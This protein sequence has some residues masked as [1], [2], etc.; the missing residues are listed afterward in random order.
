MY[1]IH[2]LFSFIIK[3][4]LKGGE[5]LNVYE[6]LRRRKVSFLGAKGELFGWD[7][8]QKVSFLGEIFQRWAFWVRILASVL[9]YNKNLSCELYVFRGLSGC[10]FV[11]CKHFLILLTYREFAFFLHH[12]VWVIITLFNSNQAILT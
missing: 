7:F 12:L 9:G 1:V 11:D 8:L 2:I 3:K 10:F 4:E 6:G 5:K